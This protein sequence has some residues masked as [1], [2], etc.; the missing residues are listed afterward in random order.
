MSKSERRAVTFAQRL[1]EEFVGELA[2]EVRFAVEAS[3]GSEH[4]VLAPRIEQVALTL[5]RPD[6][7]VLIDWEGNS[8]RKPPQAHSYK[9]L[10]TETHPDAAVLRPFRCAVEFDREGTDGRSRFKDCLLKAA[11]HV[12]SGAY[13][14]VLFVYTLTRSDSTAETYLTDY[15]EGQGHTAQLLKLLDEKGVTIAIVPPA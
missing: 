9:L 8:Q 14:G 2:G 3:G 15:E 4:K 12:L 7:E 11:C 5:A 10:G 13:D 6:E 1:R